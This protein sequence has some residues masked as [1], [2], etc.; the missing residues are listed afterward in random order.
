[1]ETQNLLAIS[2]CCHEINR[3]VKLAER[4]QQVFYRGDLEKSKKEAPSIW[5]V[6]WKRIQ[7]LV[8]FQHTTIV[9]RSS[10]YVGQSAQHSQ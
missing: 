2:L 8:S 3:Q 6:A 4:N 7:T 10:A 5:S 9:P 1:M